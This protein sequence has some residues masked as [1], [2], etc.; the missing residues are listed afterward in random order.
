MNVICFNKTKLY[1]IL[2]LLLLLVII[3]LFKNVLKSYKWKF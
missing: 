1:T 3:M 2:F